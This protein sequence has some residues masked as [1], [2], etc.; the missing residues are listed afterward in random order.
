[1]FLSLFMRRNMHEMR[2]TGNTAS[3]LR[4]VR[5]HERTRRK[6]ENV[7]KFSAM[8][9]L[10][11]MTADIGGAATAPRTA[12]MHVLRFSAEK[13]KSAIVVNPCEIIALTLHQL[14]C[15]ENALAPK[16]AR[17]D[18]VKRIGRIAR[19]LKVSKQRIDGGGSHRRAHIVCVLDTAVYDAPRHDLRD[20]RSLT[21]FSEDKR[22]CRR[23]R[24]LSGRRTL[25]AVFER[26]TELPFRRAKM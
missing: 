24:P 20:I 4:A 16:V 15:D 10:H 22:S 11:D 6:I 26:K 25:S 5:I 13:Q 2:D 21:L 14:Q 17:E 18:P 1:M 9:A 23:R 3:L 7:V 8:K 12:A 19:F